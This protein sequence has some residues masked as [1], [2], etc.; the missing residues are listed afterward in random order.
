MTAGAVRDTSAILRDRIA[1]IAAHRFEAAVDDIE[2]ADEP[3]VR[4][5]LAG[6]RHLARRAGRARLLRAVVELPPGMPAGLEASARYT[7]AAPIDL[8]ERHPRVHLRGRRDHRPGDAA[9]LHRER[10]LRPDDQPER[11]RRPDRRR[12]R[13]GHRRRA[14]RAPRVRRRRQPRDHDVH[15]LP[16]ADRVRGTRRSSTGTSRPRAPDRVATRVWAKAARS[17]RRRVSSTRS[18]TRSRRSE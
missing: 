6:D 2:I 5:G 12:R 10:R 15:G 4:P 16:A 1:A 14:L 18:P 11:R 8:G 9:A 13:A 3:R 17:A 7:A